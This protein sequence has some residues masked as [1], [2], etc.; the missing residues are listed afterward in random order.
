MLTFR[1]LGGGLWHPEAAPTSA[2]RRA[3][4]RNPRR[5]KDVLIDDRIRRDFLGGAQKSDAA[6]VKVSLTDEVMQ[7]SLLMKLLEAF[8]KSNAENA[9]KTKPKVSKSPFH[10]LLSAEHRRICLSC[11]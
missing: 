9:L 3:I 10:R 8:F 1:S 6:A 5:L 11:V 2:M 7:V 4:D